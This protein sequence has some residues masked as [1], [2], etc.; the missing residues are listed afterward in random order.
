MR[1]ILGFRHVSNQQELQEF[2]EVLGQSGADK[3]MA[4]EWEA[5][6][7]VSSWRAKPCFTQEPTTR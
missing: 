7:R 6:D 4:V 1:I 5:Q 3:G 2:L